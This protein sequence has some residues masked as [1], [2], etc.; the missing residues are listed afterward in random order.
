[1]TMELVAKHLNSKGIGRLFVANRDINRAQALAGQFSG[2]ALP[3]SEIEGTL[4]AA[5]ILISSTSSSEAVIS[6]EQMTRAVQARKR[7]PVF[8]VDIAVPRDIDPAVTGLNDV[9]LYTID[10]LDKVIVEGQSN[11]EAAAVDANQI[12]DEEIQRYL[13]M[14]R[15]KEVAPII[16][17][18]RD[19]GDAIR[20]E[21]LKQARLRLNKGASDDE[22]LEY[23]TASLLK[24]MLHQPSVRLR[25]AGELS[26]KQLIEAARELFGLG[27][28]DE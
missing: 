22:I 2:F 5:D 10:D 26:D 13:T 6:L 18:L 23:A 17:E 14:E 11:R 28:K 9:Y 24:K 19:Q 27:K 1:M 20:N 3:L 8:V 4:P 21:V 16:T 25:E 7:K 15:S 12:L